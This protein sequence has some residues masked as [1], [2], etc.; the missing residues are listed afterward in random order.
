MEIKDKHMLEESKEEIHYPIEQL[1][2]FTIDFDNRQ[3]SLCNVSETSITPFNSP[4]QIQTMHRN[5]LFDLEATTSYIKDTNSNTYIKSDEVPNITLQSE[6]M[7]GNTLLQLNRTNHSLESEI[8]KTNNVT[9]FSFDSPIRKMSME[10]TYRL[11]LEIPLIS[12]G[13]PPCIQ[14]TNNL[15]MTSPMRVGG[16]RQRSQS[17]SSLLV[18]SKQTTPTRYLLLIRKSRE[19]LKRHQIYKT[20][21]FFPSNLEE[22]TSEDSKILLPQK[23]YDQVMFYC[24]YPILIFR[25]LTIQNMFMTCHLI[26]LVI[27]FVKACVLI[28]FYY[29]DRLMVTVIYYIL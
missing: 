8:M 10:K 14:S 18:S 1:K 19:L 5:A 20:Q 9:S 26:L 23:F 29:H 16:F 22:T 7:T 13:S 21:E 12:L 17:D 28:R 24:F 25:T 6:T 27:A 3:L 4:L 2:G 15:L 11:V